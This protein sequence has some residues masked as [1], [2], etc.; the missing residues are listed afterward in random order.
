MKKREF[1]KTTGAGA[2]VAAATAV[3]AP[4]VHAQS[5]TPIKWRLQT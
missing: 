4:L 1:L 2:A 5:K 3:N